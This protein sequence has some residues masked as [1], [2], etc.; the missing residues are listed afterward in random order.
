[1]AVARTMPEAGIESWT[2]IDRLD[3]R[4]DKGMLKVHAKKQLAVP[5]RVL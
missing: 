2:D 1:M 3:V 5:S 4:P